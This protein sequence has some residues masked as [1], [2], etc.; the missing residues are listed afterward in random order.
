MPEIN[1]VLLVTN[2]LRQVNSGLAEGLNPGNL[3][4]LVAA[5]MS[6]VEQSFD[7]KGPEKKS[8]VIESIGYFIKLL[9]LDE[10]TRAIF[11]QLLINVVPN[12]ID[13][14]IQT[15]KGAFYL[16]KDAKKQQKKRFLCC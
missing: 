10:P 4:D 12:A 11:E 14:L 5:S 7:L 13:L 2:E 6:F 9:P 1:D 3:L 15:V 16:Q 8:L